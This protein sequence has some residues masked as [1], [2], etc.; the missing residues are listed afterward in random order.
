MF[1]VCSEKMRKAVGC[2]ALWT[3]TLSQVWICVNY[4][5]RNSGLRS[6]LNMKHIKIWTCVKYVAENSRLRSTLNTSVMRGL[7]MFE[8]CSEKMEKQS[9]A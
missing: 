4:V 7:D 8:V 1:E 2:V 6:I 9:I 5:A 3:Q